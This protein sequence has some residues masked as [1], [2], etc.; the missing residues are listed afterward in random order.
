MAQI[1]SVAL[2]NKNTLCCRFQ[3]DAITGAVAEIGNKVRPEFLPIA[4]QN[5]Y[6]SD[7]LQKWL[8][9]RKIPESREGLAETRLAFGD[10]DAFSKYRNFFSL[11]D[12]YWVQFRRSESWEDGNF[13]TNLY[14]TTVGEAFFNPWAVT[15]DDLKKCTNC[16]DY[17]TNGVLR[18]RW[19]Q[20]PDKTSFLIKA[21]SKQYHQEPLSEVLA[22]LVYEQLGGVLPYV[23]YDLCIE[24]MRICSTCR[25]FINEDIEF[26]PA[27]HLCSLRPRGSKSV[28]DHL[29]SVSEYYGIPE[30]EMKDFL[31]RL[32]G[33]DL[34]IGNTDRHLGNFGFLRDVN[35]G[36]LIG[37][38][39]LF[40][41]GS[42]FWGSTNVVD[43]HVRNPFFAS[44]E[45]RALKSARDLVSGIR[46]DELFHV[47]DQYPDISIEKKDAIKKAT[48]QRFRELSKSRTYIR[49]RSLEGGSLDEVTF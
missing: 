47:I 6:S 16:P 43:P 14:E 38:A 20:K 9:K 1:R 10:F 48:D 28:F 45:A 13:F 12:Q 17:V 37:F 8:E 44:Q 26:V 4:L 11:T 5:D 22:S 24:G 30:K 33:T 18:K 2:Y 40:D 31:T 25:N 42:A 49:D 36:K 29:V 7:S 35:T 34:I 32:I 19:L 41:N 21:G 46:A 23:H 15:A 39:P 27:K 3:V